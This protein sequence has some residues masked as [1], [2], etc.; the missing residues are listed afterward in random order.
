MHEA[1]VE[2]WTYLKL[3]PLIAYI[4]M[5]SIVFLYSQTLTCFPSFLFYEKMSNCI[6][7][8]AIATSFSLHAHNVWSV[9]VIATNSLICCQDTM[10]TMIFYVWNMDDTLQ[11][12]TITK[13]KSINQVCE[14]PST[15]FQLLNP[16]TKVVFECSQA[17]TF[18]LLMAMQR[19]GFF[20]LK[21]VPKAKIKNAK[22]KWMS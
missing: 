2:K 9:R 10:Q 1:L 12:F 17:W 20:Y 13:S 15:F 14:P 6:I 18:V 22:R 21:W 7:P 16:W 19:L 8:S 3:S 11:L 5:T 4:E